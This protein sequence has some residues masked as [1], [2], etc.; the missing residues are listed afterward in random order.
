MTQTI[1]G[2][3]VDK[4]SQTTLPGANVVILNTVPLKAT[5][6]DINGNFRIDNIP[7]GRHNLQVSYVGYISYLISEMQ[8]T[9]SKEIVLKV[10][11]QED[12]FV[13]DAVTVKAFKDKTGTINSMATISARTFSAE[14]TRRYAG[15]MDDPARMASAFAGVAVGNIQD[16]S[17]II[18]GNSPKGVLWRLEGVEIPSPSHFAGANVAGGGFTTLFSN[19]LLANSDFFTGA[20]PAEYGN[21]LAGVFDIKLRNGNNEKREY[22]FQVGVMGIDFA[23]EGP[24]KKGG[25]AS[26]L[27]NYRYSTFGLI[28]SFI[29]SEQIPEYQDLSFKFNFPLK[30]SAVISL[31]GIGGNGKNAEPVT[32]DSTKWVYDWDKVQYDFSSNMGAV[33]VNYKKIISNSAYIHS[34]FV[35]SSNNLSWDMKRMNDNLVLRDSIFINNT[36]GKYT[37]STFINNK[38]TKKHTNRTGIVLNNIF[39]NTQTKGRYQDEMI[40][41][42]NSKGNSYLFQAYSQSKYDISRKLLANIGVHTQYFLLNKE[43][44]IEPRLGLKYKINAKN[45]LSFGYGNHSQLEPLKVYM[46]QKEIWGGM[47]LPNKDLAFSKAHHFVIGYDYFITPN[48]RIKIE[49]YYQYLY[50]I[51]VVDDDTWSMI[52]YEQELTFDKVLVNDGTGTNIGIDFTLE[53]F[54]KNNYYYLFTAS[55]FDAKYTGGNGK[56]YN[57]RFNKNH[58][59]TFLGGKEFVFDKKQGNTRILGING[60]ISLMGGHRIVPVNEEL[61]NQEEAIYYDWSNPYVE[62]NPAD[63]FLDLTINYR[64]NKKKHSSIWMMQVKNLTGTP[65]NYMYQYNIKESKIENTSQTIMV[66]VISYKIEF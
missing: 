23:A 35:A 14:E 6:T 34:S 61:S 17:I 24:F 2:Q 47:V 38:F 16:N 60:R 26:Y 18:R 62:Q 19:H 11:L 59:F 28:K 51:P 65:S 44:S 5:T 25:K 43:F 53:R 8:V 10:Q 9:A 42:S 29:P 56:T 36:S 12:A 58:V 7:V 63:F 21:A 39:Y 1:R 13:L 4:E 46:Y 15:G 37:F 54:L 52:N 3:V 33:G 20:F 30:N 41:Y 48:L 55:L 27:I 57:S 50:N 66:P 31:W 64:I 32:E 45:N 40:D 22:A 49:P